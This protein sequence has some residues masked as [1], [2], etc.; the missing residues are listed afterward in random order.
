[1]K[2]ALICVLTYVLTYV[3]S[4]YLQETLLNGK[5]FLEAFDAIINNLSPKNLVE[6]ISTIII[7]GGIDMIKYLIN[8]L[9]RKKHLTVENKAQGKAKVTSEWVR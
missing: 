2:L 1:M 4:A 5:G 9:T 7:Q 6:I 8:S 3:L